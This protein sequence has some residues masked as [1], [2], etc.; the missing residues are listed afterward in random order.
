MLGC[1]LAHELRMGRVIIPTTPGVTSALG[2][3]VADIRNDFVRTL[4]T[5]M[6]EAMPDM[7]DTYAGL[8]AQGLDWLREEQHH[9][10]L[11]P[12]GAS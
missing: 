10:R 9:A 7:P 3:L 1:F 11:A 6:D 4:F 8:R 12:S 5:S 2:G